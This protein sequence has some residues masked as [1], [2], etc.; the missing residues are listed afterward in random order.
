MPVAKGQEVGGDLA[1]AVG[2]V[3]V[4]G[5]G[6]EAAGGVAVEHDEGSW[7]P[8]RMAVRASAAMEEAMTPSRAA[9][10]EA[11]GSRAGPMPSGEGYRRTPKPWSAATRAAPV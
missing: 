6:A 9:W 1:D 4:D 8:P 11:K 2:D 10:A 5:G 7:S 3:E